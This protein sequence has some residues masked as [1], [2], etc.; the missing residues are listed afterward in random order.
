M[1]I[2]VKLLASK[3]NA[4]VAESTTVGLSW[5]KYEK[6]RF[7][8]FKISKHKSDSDKNVKTMPYITSRRP[9][10]LFTT[11]GFTHETPGPIGQFEN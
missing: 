6:K 4:V 10:T 9:K 2:E 8:N 11:S 7:K 5:A 1:K 3:C